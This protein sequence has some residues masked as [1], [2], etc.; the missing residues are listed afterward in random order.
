V[1][2]IR[3]LPGVGS[4][5][6]RRLGFVEGILAVGKIQPYQ[7]AFQVADVQAARFSPVACGS[8]SSPADDHHG[9]G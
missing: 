8:C 6:G 9:A 1:Q 7:A 5:Q 4:L 2:G 3:D